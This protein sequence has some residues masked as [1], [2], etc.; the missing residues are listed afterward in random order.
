MHNPIRYGSAVFLL[1]TLAF[2]A[3]SCNA[4]SP[5]HSASRAVDPRA[6]LAV[7]SFNIRYGTA[8]DGPD[9]WESRRALLIDAIASHDPDIAGLQEALRFQIDEIRA[10]LPGYA[11]VGVGRDDGLTKGEYSVILY[12]ADRF[13]VAESGTFW[14]SDTPDIP[15]SKHWGN[16]I[17]RIC[18]WARLLDRRSGKAP[19]GMYV[20]NLHLDHQSEP[21]RRRAAE[22]LARRVVD[23]DHPDDPVIVT[24][25]F[26]CGEESRAIRF[27]TGRASAAV[28]NGPSVAPSPWTGLI[29]TYR[30]A[31]PDEPEPA[32][33]TSFKL[34]TPEHGSKIDYVLVSR[35][36][37]TV[38][39]AKI[40]R[41]TRD[42]RLPSDHYPVTARL[43]TDTAQAPR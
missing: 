7:M 37:F 23:R 40:D 6:D 15:G 30:V 5:S 26:N 42:G 10:A 33:F 19:R 17:T 13:D 9:R 1:L 4:P 27:L 35:G 12:R 11:E 21:S 36:V 38:L 24:G 18:S 32:T 43:R 34:D 41:T 39:E 16:G 28:E 22:M 20:F 14:F 29:D 25:D 31:H 3:L 2:T 8:N